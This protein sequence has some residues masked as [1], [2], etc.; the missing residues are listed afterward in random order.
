MPTKYID[1]EK[2]KWRWLPISAINDVFI[3]RSD[4]AQMPAADVVEVVRCRECKWWDEKKRVCEHPEWTDMD[5]WHKATDAEDYC[6]RV[7]R[8]EKDK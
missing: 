6:F 5:G 4:I 7:E 1:V 3:T 2:I 8:K